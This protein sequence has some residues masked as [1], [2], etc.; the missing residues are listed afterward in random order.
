MMVP[1]L[2]GVIFII[3]SITY[4]MPGCPATIRLGEHTSHEAIAAERERMGLND[5]FI[6]RLATYTASVA[7]LDFGESWSTNRPVFVEISA[8]FPTT[9]QLAAMGI[10][11]ALLIGIPLGILSSTRQYSIFDAGA[12]FIGLIGVSVPNFWLGMLLI[13]FFSVGLGVLPTSGWDS[14][15]HWVLPV[16]AIGTGSASIIMRMTRSSMLE[17]IRS[18]Y[19]RTARAKGQKESKIIFKHALRNALIPVVTVAGISFGMLLGGAVIT[20]T[21]FAIPGLGRFM[22]DSITRR[23]FPTVQG[24]VLLLALSFSIVNLLVDILYAF[25]DPRIRSQYN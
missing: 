1:V 17:C 3:F 20:E 7:R 25:L 23:D 11:M 12:N 15:S 8:R 2:I 6:V 10:I 19:I 13:L 4:F 5:P 9:M 24:G 14:P 22:V 21:I 18:D 16:I